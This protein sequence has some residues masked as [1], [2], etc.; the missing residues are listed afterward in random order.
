MLCDIRQLMSS[1]QT[2][3]LLPNNQNYADRILAD[4]WI[5]SNIQKWNVGSCLIFDPLFQVILN[6]DDII[7]TPARFGN[8]SFIA[9]FAKISLASF[10][11]SGNVVLETKKVKC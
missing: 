8:V 10:L 9:G 7:H 5:Q 2:K 4:D 11:N 1:F 6:E 3:F